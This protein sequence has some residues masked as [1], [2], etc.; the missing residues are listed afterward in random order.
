MLFLYPERSEGTYCNQRSLAYFQ[1]CK[2]VSS[3]FIRGEICLLCKAS[4]NQNKPPLAPLITQVFSRKKT[5]PVRSL[6]WHRISLSF[7]DSAAH[8]SP[9]KDVHLCGYF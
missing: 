1:V 8:D 2:S 4:T 5:A 3:V 6:I 9:I 7:P